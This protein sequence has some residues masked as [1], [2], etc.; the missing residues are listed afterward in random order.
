MCTHWCIRNSINA[1]TW[2]LLCQTPQ[3]TLL[4]FVIQLG[5]ETFDEW[6]KRSGKKGG[7]REE[8]KSVD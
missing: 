4:Y 2:A 7:G 5:F 1:S 6:K 8:I 3:V